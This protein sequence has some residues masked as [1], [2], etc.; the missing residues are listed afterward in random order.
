MAGWRG[1][2]G[3]L[4]LVLLAFAW[5]TRF[6]LE[7]DVAAGVIG[8]AFLLGSLS[9]LIHVIAEGSSRNDHWRI[10]ETGLTVSII[11]VIVT[12]YFL[13]GSTILMILSALLIILILLGFTISYVTP[14]VRR[15]A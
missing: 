5:T 3:P 13:T 15:E 10:L 4:L 8:L 1:L 9:Y 12:G 11:A 14:R 2:T 6:F 7:S